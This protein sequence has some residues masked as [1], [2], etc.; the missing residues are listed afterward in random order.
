MMKDVEIP[1]DLFRGK[2]NFGSYIMSSTI[3]MLFL[4]YNEDTQALLNDYITKGRKEG[5][6]EEDENGLV[7]IKESN[8]NE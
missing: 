5:L 2:E 8:K 3:G 4:Q 7:Y 6:V 1:L